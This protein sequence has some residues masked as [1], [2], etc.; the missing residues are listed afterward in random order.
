MPTLVLRAAPLAL[1]LAATAAVAVPHVPPSPDT[2]LARVPR[3]DDPVQAE[4]D[5]LGAALRE[6][7]RDAALAARYA[8]LAI[9][10]ARNLGDPRYAGQAEAALGPWQGAAAAPVRI[11]VLRATVLQHRHAFDAALREL[12]LA[13]ADEPGDA[14]ALLTRATLHQLRG[15]LD[16]A[17]RDC[18]ALAARAPASAALLCRAA[19]DAV[20]GAADRALEIAA[21]IAVA[22]PDPALKLWASTLLAQTLARLGR[23]ADAAHA[24]DEAHQAM[25]E[26]GGTDFYLVAAHAD[27]LLD[28]GRAD[29]VPLLLAPYPATDALLLRLARAERELGRDPVRMRSLREQLAARFGASRARGDAPHAREEAWFALHV[30]ADPRRALP[31]AAANWDEQREP[32]D[33]RLLLEAAL[34]AGNARAARP[35]LAWMAATGIQ[36]SALERLR[37][38]LEAAR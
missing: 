12:D 17:R 23:D 18:R 6:R 34:A 3:A 13:L 4:L 37:A 30:E 20:G 19:V 33:A 32:E 36:D 14:Q 35:V 11:R 25:L 38:R 1:L 27:F 9:Q 10:R 24:F 16:E 2:P 15:Q 7:P 28:R 22:E 5:H 29:G 31:L 21:R 8:Q 26:A